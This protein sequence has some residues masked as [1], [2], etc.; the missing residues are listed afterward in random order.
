MIAAGR[1][2]EQKNHVMLLHAFR[3]FV[4]KYPDYILHLYGVGPLEQELRALAEELRI[5]KS[6][7]FEGFHEDILNEIRDA[8]MYVLSSDYEGISNSLLEAMGIGLPVIST[9]CPCGGSRM[10]IQDGVNGLLT[11]VGE[12]GALRA[13]MEKIA[14]SEALAANLGKAA[15]EVRS[16]FSLQSIAGQ[17]L[18]LLQELS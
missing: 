2:E 10:C 5:G 7:V 18:D 17:W 15:V 6:V 8:G 13:A 1:L 12:A 9:D 4:Q 16:K 3:D 11:P 14:G